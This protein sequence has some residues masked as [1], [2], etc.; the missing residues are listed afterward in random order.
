[1]RGLQ[2]IK[3]RSIKAKQSRLLFTR[4]LIK[5]S[6]LVF[7]VCGLVK[8]LKVN[9]FCIFFCLSGDNSVTVDGWICHGPPISIKINFKQSDDSQIFSPHCICWKDASYLCGANSITLALGNVNLTLK[10]T[11]SAG[12]TGENQAGGKPKTADFRGNHR[13]QLNGRH[14]FLM[15]RLHLSVR[16]FT[17]ILK[18]KMI[19]RPLQNRQKHAC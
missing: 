10:Q 13:D 17:V 12:M 2:T 8:G 16:H 3:E 7:S 4:P 6:M 11:G 19:T 15:F 1:M 9:V 14:Q 5:L 18:A